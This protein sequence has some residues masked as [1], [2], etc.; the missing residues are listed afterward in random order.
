MRRYRR[1]DA[2]TT[3]RAERRGAPGD[4]DRN[5][6]PT[7]KGCGNVGG[8]LLEAEPGFYFAGGIG[9]FYVRNDLRFAAPTTDVGVKSGATTG[10]V[11]AITNKAGGTAGHDRDPSTIR[12]R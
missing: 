9:G 8:E 12:L 7:N 2:R 11:V 4:R 10:V 3:I 6:A 5:V 1:R